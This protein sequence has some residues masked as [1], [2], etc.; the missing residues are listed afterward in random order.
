MR[1]I[2]ETFETR[3]CGIPC[4]AEVC[5]Q[6]GTNYLITTAS[7]EPNDPADIVSVALFDRKGYPAAWLE[8]KLNQEIYDQLLYEAS[9]YHYEN[10]D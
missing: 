1:T 5:Y 9:R 2:T 8:R 4:T 6:P 10:A 7:T 3:I